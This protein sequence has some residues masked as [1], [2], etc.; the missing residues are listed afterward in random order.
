MRGLLDVYNRGPMT[1][2]TIRTTASRAVRS[3]LAL[4]AAHDRNRVIGR[5]NA[6]PW[7]LP[8]DLRHFKQLTLG[9][10]VI[11]GRKTFESI[12]ASLGKPLPGRR[13][14]VVSRS[15]RVIDGAEC[16][17][18]LDAAL[19]ACASAPHVFV[20]GGGE[21][22]ALALPIAA[23]LHLTEI[24]ASFGGDTHFPSFDRRDWREVA[25]D[26]RSSEGASGL[27]FAFVTYQ[28]VG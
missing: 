19:D 9:A 23:R 24:D 10:P 1:A 2:A 17:T 6:M 20:I 28:R 21:M 4:V 26:S 14:L 7:H 27:R 25:R 12:V 16:F 13:N 8:E 18:S 15:A 22:Y 11:Q 5:D 3:N